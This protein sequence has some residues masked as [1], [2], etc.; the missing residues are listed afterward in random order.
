MDGAVFCSGAFYLVG[1]GQI[2]GEICFHPSANPGYSDL[3]VLGLHLLEGVTPPA[4]R[5][6]FERATAGERSQ[7]PPF[8]KDLVRSLLFASSLRA[9]R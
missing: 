9:T 6:E 5:I 2:Q 8:E 7:L 4:L 3:D 1:T